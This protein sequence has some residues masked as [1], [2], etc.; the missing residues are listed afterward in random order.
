M[1]KRTLEKTE[2]KLTWYGFEKDTGCVAEGCR[3]RGK[4]EEAEMMRE[5]M[6]GTDRST[7]SRGKSRVCQV[8]CH[9]DVGLSFF[10]PAVVVH[11][12]LQ[13]GDGEMPRCE[14]SFFDANSQ[15]RIPTGQ[16]P[17]AEQVKER[18]RRV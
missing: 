10:H 11:G 15:S 17:G 1:N 3:K 4:R 12:F 2:I 13:E 6:V 7:Y 5:G 14:K 18:K 8:D 9:Q 16:S